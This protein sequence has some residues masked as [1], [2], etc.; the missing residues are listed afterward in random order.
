ML[1]SKGKE[2]LISTEENNDDEN[3]EENEVLRPE[4]TQVLSMCFSDVI[5]K[6]TVNVTLVKTMVFP[7]Q[8]PILRMTALIDVDVKGWG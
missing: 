4:Q 7:T 6:Y 2:I 1:K 3:A 8:V 5:D